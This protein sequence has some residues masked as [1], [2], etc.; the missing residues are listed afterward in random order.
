[1]T[2]RW[3]YAV[4]LICLWVPIVASAQTKS[5]TPRGELLYTTHC[6]ACHTDQIHWRDR[7]IARDW[8]SLEGQVRHWQEVAGL[9]WS[10]EDIMEVTRYLNARHYHYP[11]HIQ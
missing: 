6:I 9:T 5:D 7:K 3:R 8:T 1:M 11:E 4:L 2:K 10:D